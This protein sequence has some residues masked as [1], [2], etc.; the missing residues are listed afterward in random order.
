MGS[1]SFS[2]NL[3]GLLHK[4][5]GAGIL[6]LQPQ[7]LQSIIPPQQNHE[8]RKKA[9]KEDFLKKANLVIIVLLLFLLIGKTFSYHEQSKT[10]MTNH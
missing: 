9:V 3:F 1:Y 4:T 2:A 6:I 10:M 5:R 8:S 7:S